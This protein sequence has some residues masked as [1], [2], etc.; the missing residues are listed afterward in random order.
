MVTN[1]Q[2]MMAVFWGTGAV[3]FL[4]QGELS[5]GLNVL[6]GCSQ[7]PGKAASAVGRQQGALL[8]QREQAKDQD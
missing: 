8:D 6:Q 4:L 7:V 2:C 1:E 3:T 5:F